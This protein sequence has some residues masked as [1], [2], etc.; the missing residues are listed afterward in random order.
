MYTKDLKRPNLTEEELVTIKA[1][2]S[3]I[4]SHH[5]N[6]DKYVTA[7][8]ENCRR[9][10]ISMKRISLWFGVSIRTTNRMIFNPDLVSD[11]KYRQV[12]SRLRLMA[13]V[14]N[15]KTLQEKITRGYAL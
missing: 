12:Y 11:E 13:S 1:H 10:G 3:L 8:I 7:F 2:Q 5:I 14:D 4:L 15:V 9:S 6:L